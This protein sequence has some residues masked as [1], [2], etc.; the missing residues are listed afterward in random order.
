VAAQATELLITDLD[1]T[2]Y[3]WL[4]FYIPSYGAMIAEAS[5]ISGLDVHEL[6]QSFRRVARRHGTTEYAFALQ[7]LDV[8]P[9]VRRGESPAE[10]VRKYDSAV[11]AFRST[12]K[13]SLKLYPGVHRGLQQLRDAGIPVVAHSDAMMGY[14]SRRLRQLGVDLLIAALC[15]PEDRESADRALIAEARRI[16]VEMAEAQTLHLPSPPDVRKPDPRS[17]EPVLAHFG[18]P[19]DRV[20]YVGDSLSRDVALARRAGF[21]D[22]WARY[23]QRQDD[24]LYRRLLEITYWT[25]EEVAHDAGHESSSN[26]RAVSPSYV[27]DAFEEVV[28]V[29]LS[30]RR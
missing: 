19:P 30:A 11:H 4:G 6:N 13:R 23:G 15:A 16:P 21:L 27:I 26:D 3:D 14:V 12:R 2:L 22:I 18:V 10:I 25:D 24:D 8:L 7:E 17:I 29:V 5:R 1:N 9:E 20:A 28:P